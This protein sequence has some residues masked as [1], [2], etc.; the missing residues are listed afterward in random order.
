MTSNVVTVGPDVMLSHIAATL[1]KHRVSA[2][3][4]ADVHGAILGVISRTDL[5][6]IGRRQAG[7]H[8]HAS[9][10]TMPERRAADLIGDLDRAP[11]VVS[12]TA[13]L[14]KAAQTMCKQRVHRLFVIDAERIVGVISTL[15]LMTAVCEAKIEIPISEI[16]SKPLFS[17][18]AQQP[19]SVAVERLEQARVTGLVVLEDD[20]PVGLFTQV[21]AMESRDLPR[22]TR[23]DEVLDP[24]M[25]CLPTTTKVYRAA[26]QAQRL[27]VR[28]IIPCQDR[29]PMGIVT[30]FDFA[31]L[32]AG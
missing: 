12:P 29:E 27:E 15:D 6:R 13:T 32:V 11:V 25:L 26:A 22:D 31:K 16:M 9:V 21:E 24:S 30:G 10:L 4:V 23:I 20:W 3:A 1:A 5:V 19:I 17:V 2:L 28:R 18:K 8:R 7:S 14:Q